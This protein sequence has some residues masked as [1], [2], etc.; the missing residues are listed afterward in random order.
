MNRDIFENWFHKHLIS[1]VQVY[2]KE[3]GLPQKAGLLPD[4]APSHPTERV[5]TFA[6]CHSYYIQHGP[7][8]DCN[9]EMTLQS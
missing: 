8:S 5:L 4:N 9:H 3:T 6:P 2:L 7:R 1:E